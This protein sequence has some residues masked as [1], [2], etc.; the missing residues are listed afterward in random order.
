MRL[1]HTTELKFSS[2]DD[3]NTIPPYAILSHTWGNVEV[4][5]H[6]LRKYV[7]RGSSESE[8]YQKIQSCCALAAREGYDYV[9]IDTCCID[10]TSS[11][12]LSE[13]INSMYHWYKKAQVCYAYLSDVY[14]NDGLRSFE[15]E[16]AF[17]RSRW[18]TR[19]WTL[20]E[21]LAPM[22]VL[23]YDK[24]WRELGSR[25]SLKYRISLI[26]GIQ[27]DHIHDMNRASVAQKMSWAS[28]RKTTRIEDIAYSLMGIFNVNMPLLYGEGRKAFM[29]LQHEIVKISDDESI[30]VWKDGLLLESGLLAQSPE[31]FAY[32]GNVVPIHESHPLYVYRAPYT[33]T[34]RGLAIELF[35]HMKDWAGVLVTPLNCAVQPELGAASVF[36]KMDKIAREGFVRSSPCEWSA[37]AWHPPKL[38][39]RLAYVH[40]VCVPIKEDKRQ[41]TLTLGRETLATRG[42]SI[43]ATYNCQLDEHLWDELPEKRYWQITVGRVKGF[44]AV[45]L[46]CSGPNL[47]LFGVIFCSTK[48]L[49]K[50]DLIVPSTDQSFRKE[51][52]KYTVSQTFNPPFSPNFQGPDAI[53]R[54]LQ[55]DRWVSLALERVRVAPGTRHYFVKF[56]SP[57]ISGRVYI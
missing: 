6:I 21:L 40:P 10:K 15:I 48:G 18:F 9:W 2:F 30:F 16:D 26:T 5:F 37:V 41:E 12:E 13:A 51:M 25:W 45:L 17:R 3:D 31:A 7:A 57:N 50:I 27:Q 39:T 14:I 33:V 54:K 43:L 23:F 29:R 1:L 44:G 11:A 42:L 38:V 20:Q 56:V 4:S 47:L 22:R 34:N 28:K 8:G 55:D 53:S 35:Q 19:G 52:D 36:I 24:Q 46:K 32:S 49:W